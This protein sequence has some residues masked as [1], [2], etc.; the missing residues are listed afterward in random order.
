MTN[1]TRL[2]NHTKVGKLPMFEEEKELQ[3]FLETN[4]TESLK[5]MIKVTIKSMIKGEMEEV[6]KNMSDRPSFNG[7]YDRNLLST[8]GKIDDIPVPRFRCDLPGGV[9]LK[10]LSVFDAEKEKFM[11]LAGEMHLLGISQRKIK[12]LMNSCLGIPISVTRVG[13][14]YKE[15]VEKEEVN[16]NGQVLDDD[17]QIII[18]DGMWEITKGYGWEDNRSVILCA[19][20]V[21]PN[22]ERKILGFNLARTEDAEG[23]LKLLGNIKERGLTGA[24]LIIA[25][26]DDH[27]GIKTALNNTFPN[28]PIQVCIAHKMRNA[29]GKTSHKNKREIARDVKAV[30]DSNSKEEAEEKARAVVK[31]W[32]MVEPKAMES[33]RF[34]LEFCFTYFGFPKELWSKIRTSNI[35]EREIREVRRRMKVF[36]NTFQNAESGNRYANSIFSYLNDNYPLRSN[37]HTAT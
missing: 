37:L 3:K 2:V 24:N 20:G 8:F 36:D 6:R 11:K 29:I 9:D 22:G 25:I 33:F 15:L 5:Q 18:V 10:S 32:Y 28:V 14:I 26:A 4:F 16:I 31:K 35:L 30:F 7:C 12:K 27:M 17:F 13:A 19:L 23:Y 21:R 34:N 1:P